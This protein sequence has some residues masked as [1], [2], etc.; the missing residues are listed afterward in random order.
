M[1]IIHSKFIMIYMEAEFCPHVDVHVAVLHAL[2]PY[3]CFFKH[4]QHQNRRG[5]NVTAAEDY[6]LITLHYKYLDV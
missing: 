2:V 1:K 5:T 4:H 6:Y 3:Y